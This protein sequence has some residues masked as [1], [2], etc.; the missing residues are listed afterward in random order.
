MATYQRVIFGMNGLSI[1]W[2]IVD[3]AD[4]DL[5]FSNALIPVYLAA[6][7]LFLSTIPLWALAR[8]RLRGPV[9]ELAGIAMFAG[10]FAN[11]LGLLRAA[12]T[13]S[14]EFF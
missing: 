13:A 12:I 14:R 5:A 9:G 10:L 2:W 8:W 4:P 3:F 11:S 7:G 1:V 6:I